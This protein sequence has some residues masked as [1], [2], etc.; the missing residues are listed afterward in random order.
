MTERD[1]IKGKFVVF[2]GI[3]GAGKTT[4]ARRLADWLQ[5]QG[6]EVILTKEPG[7]IPENLPIRALLFDLRLSEDGMAQLLLFSADRRNHLLLQIL[8]A[9]KAGQTVICDRYIGST[10]VYQQERGVDPA[11][12]SLAEDMVITFEGQRI[13]PDVTILL[14]V[15]PEDGMARKSQE[16][17][18][19]FDEDSLEIQKIRRNAYLALT[20]NLFGWEVVDGGKSE[21]EVFEDIL[22]ILR[23]RGIFPKEGNN[24]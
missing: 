24:E 2:E 3:D 19:Y 8:P 20:Q 22:Q 13:E 10:R 16:K 21:E 4:Q 14:D 15:N 9:L 23:R 18:N 12:I 6:I 7:G 17:E 5:G 11:A 1:Q